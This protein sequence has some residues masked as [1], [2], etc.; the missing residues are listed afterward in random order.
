MHLGHNI[1]IR[2]LTA[3]KSY[4]HHGV[5]NSLEILT[6]LSYT[7]LLARFSGHIFSGGEADE[8]TDGAS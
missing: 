1:F 4:A 7:Q 5:N 6:R 3:Q 8:C 2:A